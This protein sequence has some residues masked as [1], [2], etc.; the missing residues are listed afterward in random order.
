MNT[1]TA[2]SVSHQVTRLEFEAGQPYQKSRARSARQLAGH[3]SRARCRCSRPEPSAVTA[4]GMR[5]IR[6]F[7]RLREGGANWQSS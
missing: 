3:P 4:P 7:V 2:L 6:R 1:P 5:G